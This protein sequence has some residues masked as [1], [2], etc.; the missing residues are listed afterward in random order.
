MY[1]D[2]ES[3]SRVYRL[4]SLVSAAENNACIM[5]FGCDLH[6][7]N[8]PEWGECY[9]D[10]DLLK[11]LVKYSDTPGRISEWQFCTHSDEGPEVYLHLATDISALECFYRVRLCSLNAAE[12]E[13]CE[14]LDLGTEPTAITN[15]WLA[16]TSANLNLSE[17]T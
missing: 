3:A 13:I 12:T 11:R 17:R 4:T 8:I 7:P 10:Y 15:E 14:L 16:G 9:V 2:G 1:T 6:R 5:R